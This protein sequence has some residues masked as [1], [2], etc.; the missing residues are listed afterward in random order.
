MAWTQLLP[1]IALS[2]LVAPAAQA[3]LV[4]P[5]DS[6][7]DGVLDAEDN[8]LFAPNAAQIDADADGYGNACD[9]D[10]NNDG[11]INVQDLGILRSVFFTNDLVADLTG[12]GVVNFADLG[13][14]KQAFFQQPGPAGVARW[15][16]G[17]AG[18]WTEATNWLPAEVPSF[19]QHIVIDTP[20]AVTLTADVPAQ[21]LAVRSAQIDSA[22]T[23]CGGLLFTDYGVRVDGELTLDCSATLIAGTGVAVGGALRTAQ[24]ARIEDTVLYNEPDQAGTLEVGPTSFADLNDVSLALDARVADGGAL[25]LTGDTSLSDAV[26][27]VEAGLSG[28]SLLRVETLNGLVG[29]GS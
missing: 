22:V 28:A 24:D 1:A 4:S 3:Q 23:L 8:C 29:S 10:L 9:A 21:S 12:D 11:V 25:L 14:M 18:H 7:G 6:D 17:T 5:D 16:G 13:A 20:A 19:L 27:T 15:I 26:L 2:L